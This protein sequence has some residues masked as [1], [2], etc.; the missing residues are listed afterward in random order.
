MIHTFVGSNRSNQ[1]HSSDIKA[2]KIIEDQG[3]PRGK[4]FISSSAPYVSRELP[5]QFE[6]FD[7]S[8]VRVLSYRVHF[9]FIEPAAVSSFSLSVIHGS[10]R[11]VN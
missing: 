9:L 6:C 10:V 2:F 8:T 1:L 11:I 4:S 3:N 7:V 5:G